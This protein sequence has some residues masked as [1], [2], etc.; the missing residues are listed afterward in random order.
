MT[1]TALIVPRP[2]SDGYSNGYA[3]E[4]KVQERGEDRGENPQSCAR[5][6]RPGEGALGADDSAQGPRLA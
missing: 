5:G 2:T 4:P 1:T 6:G 3:P